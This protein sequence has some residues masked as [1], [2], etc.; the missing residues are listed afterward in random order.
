M[1]DMSKMI[2]TMKKLSFRINSTTGNVMLFSRSSRRYDVKMTSA[3]NYHCVI[4]VFFFFFFLRGESKIQENLFS[5]LEIHLL[6]CF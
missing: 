4:I 2:V 3:K 6:H 1:E 5:V